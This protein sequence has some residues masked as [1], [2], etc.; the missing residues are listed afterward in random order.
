MRAGDQAVSRSA[1]LEAI[2]HFSSGLKLA[3]ALPTQ[4]RMRR[5]LDFL[6]KLG[7]ASVV[8]HGLQSVEVEEAYTRASEIGEMLGDRA[9]SFQAN[10]AFG[11][12][13]ISDA[14]RLSPAPA[15]VS[16]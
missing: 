3:E 7:A 10:G 9:K 8:A 5:Q 11:S 2:A 16:S 14:R 15:P 4:E 1:Y 12:T 13:P 6:L